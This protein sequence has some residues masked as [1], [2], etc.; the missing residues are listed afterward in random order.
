MTV[1]LDTGTTTLICAER[2]ARIKNLT[3]ITNSAQIAEVFAKGR[4]GA[5]IHLLGGRYRGDNAQTVGGA[6][7]AQIGEYQADMA[8]ITV[9]AIDGGGVT[10]FSSQE[11]DVARAMIKASSTLTVVADHSKFDQTARFRL[12]DLEQLSAL[13]TNQPPEARLRDQLR[14]ASVEV[15]E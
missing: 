14:R 11:A 4:G 7:I 8:I 6:C 3:V 2:L 15:Y 10:D 1:F 9:G 5:D 12:C 13:V